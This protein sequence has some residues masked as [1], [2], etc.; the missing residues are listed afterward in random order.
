MSDILHPIV[1]GRTWGYIDRQGRVVVEPQYKSADIFCDGLARVKGAKHYGFVDPTGAL[2]LDGLVDV[3]YFSCGL[4]AA[5]RGPKWGYIDRTGRF[6]IPPRFSIITAFSEGFAWVREADSG[7]TGLIDLRGEW[8]FPEPALARCGFSEGLVALL[9]ADG[10]F[11]YV[12]AAGHTVI[13]FRFSAAGAFSEG[14]AWVEED[15]VTKFIDR[16]G[17]TVLSGDFGDPDGPPEEKGFHGGRA[18]IRERRPGGCLGYV[19]RDE[20]RLVIPATFGWAYRFAEGRAVAGPR[21]SA[22][23]YVDRDG[24][25]VVRPVLVTAAHFRG[26]LARVH[27]DPKR[28]T[29]FGYIDTEGRWVWQPA[30]GFGPAYADLRP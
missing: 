30:R 5:R 19:G 6:V 22:L 7:R 14:L 29:V 4:A 23:G 20:G 8:V 12:D 1:E 24:D 21:S 13:P 2:V 3:T 26:G 28:E 15:G 27:P 18:L 17:E 25:F 10:R 16:A 9:G 11:G